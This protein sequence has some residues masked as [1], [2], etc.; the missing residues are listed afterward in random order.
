[1]N[2]KKLAKS[3]VWPALLSALVAPGVGQIFNRDYKRGI[4]LL[5]ISLGGFFWFS[6]VLT[7]QLSLFI[8][9]APETWMQNP[10][11]LKDAL[12]KVVGQNPDMFVTFYT[13]M[14][15]TWIFGV[16]DAYVSARKLRNFIPPP[17]DEDADSLR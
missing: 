2:I 14:F 15:L 13:L 7:Q 4:L 16:V 10:N 8:H 5:V 17:P 9:T 12:S 1:M 3:P 6:S 11:L